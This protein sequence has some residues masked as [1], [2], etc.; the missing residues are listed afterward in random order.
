M[1]TPYHVPPR[2]V[3]ATN[4]LF[5]GS[6]GIPAGTTVAPGLGFVGDMDT[7][8]HR[9]SAN[10]LSVVVGGT[11]ALTAGSTGVVA[12]GPVVAPV[13]R[14]AQVTIGDDAVYTHQMPAGNNCAV[15][16]VYTISTNYGA[17]LI[18][19]FLRVVGG[20]EGIVAMFAGL[21]SSVILGDVTGTSG[22]DGHLILAAPPGPPG[23][24]KIVNRTGASRIFNIVVL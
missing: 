21:A 9:P 24:F 6:V 18:Q 22:T 20:N 5:S 16:L 19:A 4:P 15:V 12:S 17:W 7:G 11:P 10:M 23:L 2:P 3:P 13:W 1:N 14:T 8:L